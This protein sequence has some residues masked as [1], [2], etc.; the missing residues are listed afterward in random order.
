M[1]GKFLVWFRVGSS[2]YSYCCSWGWVLG[3]DTE[4]IGNGREEDGSMV[5]FSFLRFGFWF[6][7]VFW[8]FS[9]GVWEVFVGV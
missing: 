5:F 9:G 2:S 7:V 8:L 6:R 4:V 1:I 3:F